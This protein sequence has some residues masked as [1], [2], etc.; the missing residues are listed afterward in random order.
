M[1]AHP[2]AWCVCRVISYFYMTLAYV[3][4]ASTRSSWQV[5][6]MLT[7]LP[8]AGLAPLVLLS[9]FSLDFHMSLVQKYRRDRLM[10][11]YFCKH[12]YYGICPFKRDYQVLYS[13]QDLRN[14]RTWASGSKGV[15]GGR[16]YK[17][18]LIRNK[19]SYCQ[20]PGLSSRSKPHG[21]SLGK[22]KG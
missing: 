16:F 15:Y 17:M 13:Q 14:T 1:L 20:G 11:N 22:A 19:L 7:L 6:H 8:R 9:G 2:P 3:K 12:K 21:K 4:L 10:E 5:H 18:I